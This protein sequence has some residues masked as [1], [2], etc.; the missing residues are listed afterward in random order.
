MSLCIFE[1]RFERHSEGTEW[2][3]DILLSNSLFATTRFEL[4]NIIFKHNDEEF[5]WVHP[6][7]YTDRENEREPAGVKLQVWGPEPQF[8]ILRDWLRLTPDK[9]YSPISPYPE[10]PYLTCYRQPKGV[11]S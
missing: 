9:T 11:G 2:D 4:E 10:F 6:N 1:F 3:Y 7:L 8:I 5:A